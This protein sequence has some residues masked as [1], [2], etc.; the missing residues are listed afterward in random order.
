MKSSRSLG[1]NLAIRQG[2]I[3]LAG[4]L[5]CPRSGQRKVPRA[6]ARQT[7]EPALVRVVYRSQGRKPLVVNK[8]N[9]SP[10][11]CGR[12]NRWLQNQRCCIVK[13]Q[14][15][16][17]CHPRKRGFWY[18]CTCLSGAYAPGYHMPPAQVRAQKYRGLRPPNSNFVNQR[19][20][21][22]RTVY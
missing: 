10:H 19:P 9:K 4:W 12:H 7:F 20:V 22:C 17:L 13:S 1:L 15:N 2:E 21:I 3:S 8:R 5:N 16:R 18:V 14:S 6:Y 11:M